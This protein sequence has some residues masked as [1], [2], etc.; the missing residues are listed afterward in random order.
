MYGLMKACGCSR[1]SEERRARRLH[2]C[3]TCKTMGSLYGQRSRFLLNNDAVFLGEL[4]TGLTPDAPST[5]TWASSYQ[6][7]NCMTLPDAPE[8]MP[9]SLQIAASAT[10]VMSE[11]KVADQIEDGGSKVWG[12]ALRVYSQGFHDA[13]ARLQEWGF[14]VKAMWDWYATQNQ[15]EAEA[16]RTR[17]ER[18]T[19]ET[20]DLLSEATGTVTG[21]VFR[22]GAEHVGATIDSQEIMDRIGLA[23]GRLVYTLDALEDYEKDVRK[24][25]FNAFQA[26]YDL[27]EATLSD[28]VWDEASD[29]LHALATEIRQGM[30][31]LPLPQGQAAKYA[32][33]L[34]TNL[35]ARLGEPEP[36]AC[37]TKK[38]ARSLKARWNA[39]VEMAHSLDSRSRQEKPRWSQRLTAPFAFAGVT[40]VALFA[41][42]LAMEAATSR[43]CLGLAFNLMFFGAVLTA[44]VQAPK[45]LIPARLSVDGNPPPGQPQRGIGRSRS[46]R[47]QRVRTGGGSGCCL[48]GCCDACNCACCCCEGIECG[49]CCASGCCEA[50]GSCGACGCG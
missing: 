42:R 1:S 46:T 47:V 18:T 23:F 33:R 2:Y 11:F 21:L 30:Q 27:T 12:V 44:L 28:E 40:L 35:R 50:C 49:E 26:V 34:E 7:Y 6:S 31:A 22:H 17:T 5:D 41:P 8:E 16:T 15:R 13:S 43:E 24:G 39:A 14:P 10:L 32:S 38:P 19:K 45:Q 4:L 3:G 25:D 36:A 20:L 37:S 48:N 9:L 29:Y